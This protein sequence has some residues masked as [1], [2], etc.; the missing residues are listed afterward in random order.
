MVFRFTGAKGVAPLMD[1]N[2]NP[3]RDWRNSSV[4]Q[5]LVQYATR[6][7]Y[8]G[9]IFDTGESGKVHIDFLYDGGWYQSEL[10]ILVLMGWKI[11]KQDRQNSFKKQPAAL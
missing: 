10:A 4:G 9:G 2:V 5:E 3:E 11:S 8:S 6:P 7:K 1:N